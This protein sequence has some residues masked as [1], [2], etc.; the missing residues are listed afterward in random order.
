MDTFKRCDLHVHSSSCFSRPYCK[1]DFIAALKESDL[2]VVAITDHN[3]VDVS[4]IEEV[5]RELESV[6]KKVLAGVELSVNLSSDTIEEC[7]LFVP[8]DAKYFQAVVWC[9]ID[10]AGQLQDRVCKLLDSI[11]IGEAERDAAGC[12]K[13][14]SRMSDGKSFDFDLVKS[15]FA[16][17]DHYF[18]FHE[19][20]GD[21]NLSDYLPNV[22]YGKKHSLSEADVEKLENNEK[23]KR[24]LFYYNESYAIEGGEKSSK[25]VEFFRNELSTDVS[26]FFCSDATDLAGIGSKYT[27]I[28]FDGDLGSLTL[29]ISDPESRIVTS[30]LSEDQPQRNTLDYLEA[31]KFEISREGSSEML[32]LELSPG[33]NGIIGARGSGKSLLAN[34]LAGT[35]VENYNGLVRK[36]SIAY[37]YRGGAFTPDPPKSLFLTQGELQSIFMNEGY[38]KVPFLKPALERMESEAQTASAACYEDIKAECT[39]LRE[40]LKTFLERHKGRAVSLATLSRIRP[41]GSV[42][43]RLESPLPDEHAFI[44]GVSDALGQVD[45]DLQSANE[46]LK[47]LSFDEGSYSETTRL[48]R[49]IAS[50]FS[51]M[52]LRIASVREIGAG[53]VKTLDHIQE[54]PFRT[55][56]E[57][58]NTYSVMLDESN[59]E[60]STELAQYDRELEDARI[61]L[62]D[63]LELRIAIRS[64]FCKMRKLCA[65]M[66][67][68]IEPQPLSLSDGENV[69]ISLE[70]EKSTSLD[71]AVSAQFA[72]KCKD[73]AED[74]ISWFAIEA[75]EM[76]KAASRFNGTKYRSANSAGDYADRFFENILNELKGNQELKVDLDFDD[77]SLRDMSPGMQAQVLLKLFLRGSL[78]GNG[79]KC[80][81]LDQ[82]EDNLDTKTIKDF[83]VSELKRLK[84]S[85]QLFVVSHSAPVIVNG[86]ARNIIVA[87]ENDGKISYT[88]GTINGSQTKQLIADILDGGERYLKMRLYKYDFQMED[89][90]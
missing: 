24:K 18:V 72:A 69:T 73:L 46:R 2:E 8:G 10:D 9:E 59:R 35:N 61:F 87:H 82:P 71:D 12:P 44:E 49:A 13:G 76:S 32:E 19:S 90:R 81:I 31:V 67:S 30:D 22:G 27:W 42:I 54:E 70:F 28:D 41:D 4:L 55:R 58:A 21:N 7:G 43:C 1:D 39:S 5:G 52:E 77:K 60:S 65:K 78:K 23:F 57:L 68:P 37:K 34:V 11:G 50:I 47:N 56:L 20:K 84:L 62:D 74:N 36:D 25:V 45:A 40:E 6:G 66:L 86:D 14:I 17:I 3:V 29:A 38:S 16:D 79:F 75:E 26:S 83:L 89:E 63:F 85:V 33:Y 51:E 88:P 53:T 48:R 64:A 80:I 15:F